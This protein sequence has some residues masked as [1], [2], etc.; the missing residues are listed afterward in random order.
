ML[1]ENNCNKYYKN[2]LYNNRIANAYFAYLTIQ[3][4]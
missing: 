3:F 4:A 1:N 2:Y